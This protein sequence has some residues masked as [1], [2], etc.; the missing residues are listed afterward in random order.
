MTKKRGD[1]INAEHLRQGS[2]VNS[3]YVES[4][5]RYLVSG[6]LSAL[7]TQVMTSVA[8]PLQAGDLITNITF[9][10]ATT[11][12]GTPTN[13]WFALYSNASTP[14]LLAQTADQTSTAWAANTTKTLALA[15]AQLISVTGIYYASVMVK[16]TTTPTLAGAAALHHADLSTGLLTTEKVLAVTSGSALTTT[17]PATIATPTAV[18]TIPYCVLT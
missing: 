9:K 11:A 17:A 13:Y 14:A 15:T 2:P 16:A 3:T 18:T 8:V 4:V 1:A 6:N 10:S 12:A 7:T 5:P